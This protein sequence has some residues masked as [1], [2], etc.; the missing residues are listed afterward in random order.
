MDE[1]S[2]SATSLAVAAL[3]ISTLPPSSRV[4]STDAE[5]ATKIQAV[6]RGKL[7]R[8]NK[9][10]IIKWVLMK[11]YLFKNKDKNIDNISNLFEDNKKTPN[12][13]DEGDN[14]LKENTKDSLN[15]H[16]REQFEEFL[17]KI[18]Q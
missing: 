10:K 4:S 5:A 12:I 3:A 13:I 11:L 14:T 6:I 18:I 16:Y 1:E 8:L 9:S 15:Q 7:A 2:Q 17:N